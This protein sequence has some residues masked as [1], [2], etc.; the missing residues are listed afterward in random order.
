MKE[1]QEKSVKAERQ[2]LDVRADGFT[3]APFEDSVVISLEDT[4]SDQS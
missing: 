1:K 3:R 4:V 2:G